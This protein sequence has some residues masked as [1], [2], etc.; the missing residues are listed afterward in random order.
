[1][2][3]SSPPRSLAPSSGKKRAL[4]SLT[5]LIDVV[6]ILLVFFMLVSSFADWR[7][8]DVT[9]PPAASGQSQGFTGAVLVEVHGDGQVRLSGE[10]LALDQIADRLKRLIDGA[11]DRRFIVK[12]SERVRLQDLVDVLDRLAAAGAADITFARAEGAG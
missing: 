5:P 4:V 8:I 11:P 12:T 2:P 6:F 3:P 7:T 1:M 9:P 10:T